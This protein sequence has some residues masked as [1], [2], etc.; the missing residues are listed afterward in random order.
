MNR[1]LIALIALTACN[2]KQV[3]EDAQCSEE[4]QGLFMACLTSGC[5]ASYT[6]DLSGT[7]A[8]AVEGGGSVV[9][10]EA[11][12]ECGF[13]SSGSCYV[14]CDCP[15]GVGV[16]FEV[17]EEPE[18]VTPAAD[19]EGDTAGECADGADNDRDGLYDCADPNCAN[20]PDCQEDPIPSDTG[21]LVEDTGAEV[22]PD[23][24]TG[25]PPDEVVPDAD[26]DGYAVGDGDCDDRNPAINPAASDIVGDTRDQNCD[27]IDG[28]DMDGDG[29]A[30]EAS[31]GDD[32]N[33]FDAVINPDFGIRDVTDYVDSNCDGEDGLS[34]EYKALFL[35][36]MGVWDRGD[37]DGDGLSDMVVYAFGDTTYILFGSTIAGAASERLTVADVDVTLHMATRGAGSSFSVDPFQIDDIDGD[38]SD[39][40]AFT[41]SDGRG[42]GRSYL[43]YGSTIAS[44]A[45]LIPGSNEDLV[46][47]SSSTYTWYQ[48]TLLTFTDDLTG[49]GVADVWVSWDG[50]SSKRL[51]RSAELRPS[52]DTN[53]SVASGGTLFLYGNGMQMGG[54]DIDGDGYPEFIASC[55]YGGS[56]LRA[57][58]RDFNVPSADG[59]NGYINY[60]IPTMVLP[61]IDGDGE[62]E[63]SDGY[64]V[65]NVSNF[66]DSS[67]CDHRFS[68]SVDPKWFVDV[69][70]DNRMDFGESS[71][72]IIALDFMDVASE[73]L[74]L[75]TPVNWDGTGDY[76]GDG[77]VD[78]VVGWSDGTSIIGIR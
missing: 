5:S 33:D 49:D 8:C 75:N 19:Y 67:Y 11:G 14:V 68:S 50:S 13:T 73:R 60:F 10:V 2:S 78:L 25:S 71:G 54:R 31:G 39:D 56:S 27:G 20:S 48:Q 44:T 22:E 52:I 3:V 15:E 36:G 57:G 6:Q 12:G 34:Y 61:D 45:N 21:D 72:R 38:G 42:S 69:D 16:E 26:G 59:C 46:V 66:S 40:L 65:Q 37:F 58:Y 63:L 41:Y 29:F 35:E 43:Y 74:E 76:D 7:D 23:P 17:E 51:F 18:V 77:V 24:D 28:T 47:Y 64:C 1:T 30:S 70:G 53:D 32:C 55:L 4:E 62:L 9:S